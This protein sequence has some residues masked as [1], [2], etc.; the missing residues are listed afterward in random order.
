M[1]LRTVSESFFVEAN[2]VTRIKLHDATLMWDRD[3]EAT[4]PPNAP[5]EDRRPYGRILD[6]LAVISG[7]R[8]QPYQNDTL[9]RFLDKLVVWLSQFPD[10]FLI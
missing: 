7:I 5:M 3:Y 10:E 4:L 6:P 1:S 2:C 8:F 9:P